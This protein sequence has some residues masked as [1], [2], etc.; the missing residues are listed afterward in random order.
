MPCENDVGNADADPSI[1]DLGMNPT[2]RRLIWLVTC[3]EVL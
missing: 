1:L 3:P 2:V